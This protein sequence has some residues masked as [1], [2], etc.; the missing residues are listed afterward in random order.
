ML[1]K[2][3]NS[4]RCK[5]IA[6]MLASV[7]FLSSFTNPTGKVV[8]LKSGTMVSLELINRVTSDMKVGQIVDFRVLSDVKAGGEVVIKAGT[9]AKGQVVDISKNS[10]LGQPG[11]VTLSVKSV[12]AVDGTRVALTGASLTSEGKSKL[13][14]SIVFTLLCILGFLIKGEEGKIP[15][16]TVFDA[17]VA[18]DTEVEIA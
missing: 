16:G 11:E 10:M 3:L 15:P 2:I 12:T 17:M 18:T 4:K 7:F 6:L 5:F 13:A 1:T 8:M 9:I 14:V